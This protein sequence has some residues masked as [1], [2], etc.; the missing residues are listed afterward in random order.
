MSEHYKVLSLDELDEST[1]QTAFSIR[2]YE[3]SVAWL[4]ATE[5]FMVNGTCKVHT[6]WKEQQLVAAIPIVSQ[7]M[8]WAKTSFASL[9][10]FYS[11]ESGLYLTK[12]CE[13][14]A[15]QLLNTVVEQTDVLQLGPL[16]NVQQQFITAL[17]L[18]CKRVG[19]Q[20][21]WFEQ[22]ITSEESYFSARP[23]RLK[24]TLKRKRN[25]LK[26]NKVETA[27]ATDIDSFHQ[28]FEDF[29]AIYKKSWK[30]PE[31]SNAFIEQVS[32]AAFKEN[33]LVLA[34]FYVDQVPAAAQLWYV[35]QENAS[36]FKLAY[37][38]QYQ[39]YSVGSLLSEAMTRHVIS[40]RGVSYIDF[41]MGN[42]KYKQD[43]MAYHQKRYTY[44]IFNT[45]RWSGKLAWV[46]Y[47]LLPAIKSS[48]AT[49]IRK[50][51]DDTRC[52]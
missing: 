7:K 36:I 46:R 33:K 19:E 2:Y 10:S 1:W 43:W 28:L 11:C 12:P 13:K 32:L 23:S 51:K 48:V 45:R 26:N 41:G 47:A 24:N 52:S 40:E 16:S 18:P 34:V 50:N 9:N 25:A 30:E 3:H 21:N 27:F 8:A 6:L 35:Q 14:L 38:P 37:D 5:Q 49:L 31:F 42:E 17:P 39:H 20:V 15:R 4:K 44:L 22:Q 29:L